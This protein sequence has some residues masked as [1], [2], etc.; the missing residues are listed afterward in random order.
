MSRSYFDHVKSGEISAADALA[1][2]QARDAGNAAAVRV[3]DLAGEYQEPAAFGL[4]DRLA[5]QFVKWYGAKA[6]GEVFRHYARICERREPGK[7]P[8]A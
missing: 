6:A 7:E 1:M 3:F 4:L 2:K 8:A 5:V